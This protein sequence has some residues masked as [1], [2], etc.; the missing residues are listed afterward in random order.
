LKDWQIPDKYLQTKEDREA[1]ALLIGADVK[2]LEIIAY[3]RH[4]E[5]SDE[6]RVEKLELSWKPYEQLQQG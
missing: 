6:E 3:T 2:W 5:W 1:Y 4:P